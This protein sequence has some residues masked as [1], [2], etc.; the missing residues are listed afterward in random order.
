MGGRKGLKILKKIFVPRSR[1][2]QTSLSDGKGKRS[3]MLGEGWQ[4][5]GD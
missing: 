5:A 2:S 3:N 4:E 1:A